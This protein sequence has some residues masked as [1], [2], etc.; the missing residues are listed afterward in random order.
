MPQEKEIQTILIFSDKDSNIETDM[1]KISACIE[2][3][4]VQKIYI[5]IPLESAESHSHFAEYVLALHEVIR[6]KEAIQLHEV[7]P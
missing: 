2:H 6:R 1:Q 3:G 7:M 4:H 5:L